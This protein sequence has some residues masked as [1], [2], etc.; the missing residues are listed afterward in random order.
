MNCQL[1]QKV[2]DA[3]RHGKLPDDTKTQVEDHLA[4]CKECT[5]GY[6]IQALADRVINQEKELLSNPF[7]VTR[8]MERIEDPETPLYKPVLIFNKVLRPAIITSLLAAA[9]LSGIM[10]GNFYKPAVTL[11]KIPLELALMDDA[12][13]ESVNLFANE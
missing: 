1:C 4:T 8:I 10:M 2:S 13:I 11:R 12:T 9:V 7:L 6:K 3:Y 5:E